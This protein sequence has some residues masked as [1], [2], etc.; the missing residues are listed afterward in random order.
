MFGFVVADA[1]AL[2]EEEKAEAVRTRLAAEEVC[3]D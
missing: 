1:G 3:A 2:S